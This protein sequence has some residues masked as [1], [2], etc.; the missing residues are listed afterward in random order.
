VLLS[1][2]VFPPVSVIH[3]GAV[4]YLKAS[5]WRAFVTRAYLLLS[6]NGL[7]NPSKKLLDIRYRRAEYHPQAS[8]EIIKIRHCKSSA[9]D[10]EI[11]NLEE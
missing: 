11:A 4:E 9:H 8:L 5:I 3:Q 7:L 1:L 2:A 10:S 6:V